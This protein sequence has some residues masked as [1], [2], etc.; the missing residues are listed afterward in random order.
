MLDDTIKK[1]LTSDFFPTWKINGEKYIDLKRRMIIIKDELLQIIPETKYTV[2]VNTGIGV[3]YEE[4]GKLLEAPLSS[5]SEVP[6]IGIHSNNENFDSKSQTGVYLTILFN[7]SGSNVSLSLQY[8]SDK[9]TSDVLN[10]SNLKYRTLLGLEFNKTNINLTAKD[11][12]GKLLKPQSRAKK[13]ETANIYGK[14]FYHNDINE[15]LLDLPKF[16]LV[17]EN[18]IDKIIESDEALYQIEFTSVNPSDYSEL[19]KKDDFKIISIDI[20]SFKRSNKEK[21]IAIKKA[22]FKCELNNEH[23]T[24]L[25]ESCLNYVEGHHIIPVELYTEFANDI[26]HWSNIISLCPNCHRKIHLANKE[27]KKEIISKIWATRGELL[28]ENFSIEMNELINYYTKN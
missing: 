8:G 19:K 2:T 26:D 17:Y 14:D 18:L 5:L 10:N 20:N 21:S 15:L 12:T 16:I 27:I 9:L 4:N 3:K 22:G 6:W 24:F 13:Y 1:I 25:T 28:K 7:A 23:E 11:S